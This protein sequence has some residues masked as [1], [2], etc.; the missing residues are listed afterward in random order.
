MSSFDGRPSAKDG[1]FLAPP[2]QGSVQTA[3]TTPPSTA[4]RQ[5]DTYADASIV[6]GGQEDAGQFVLYA[7]MA[8]LRFAVSWLLSWA[9]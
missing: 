6:H 5:L 7:P 3:T 1:P 8:A 4:S 9:T 2:V